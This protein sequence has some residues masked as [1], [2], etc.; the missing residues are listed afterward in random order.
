[1]RDINARDQIPERRVKRNY[2]DLSVRKKSALST[3]AT[4]DGRMEIGIAGMFGGARFAVIFIHGRNGDR[5]LGMDDYRFGGNFNRI[6][7]LAVRNDGV[8]IAPTIAEFG[9]AGVRDVDA[10]IAAFRRQNPGAPVVLACGSMGS[11]ICLSLA[12]DP[13]AAGNLAGMI[14]LGGMPDPELASSA[15][16]EAGVPITFVHG[17]NDGV[18]DWKSQRAVFDA[19]KDGR[20]S[21][22]AT[23]ILL[24]TGSHGSPVRMIDWR[25]T[26]NGMF[27]RY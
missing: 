19:I 18:Y 5:R 22:P 24:N 4:K 2:V 21:Y 14:L 16:V 20:K 12:R 25:E 17:S 6:K 7:N 23:F 27:A 10:L 11:I 1:M 15:L 8:Y 26:L 3:F 9:T 13:A